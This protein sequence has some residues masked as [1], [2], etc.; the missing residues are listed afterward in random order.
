PLLGAESVLDQV[1]QLCDGHDQLAIGFELNTTL[2]LSSFK[3]RVIR[4]L[5][6]LRYNSP[7]VGSTIESGR[8]DH[9]LRSWVYKPCASLQEARSWAERTLQEVQLKDEDLNK[10]AQILVEK[11][12]EERVGSELAGQPFI[13]FLVTGSDGH[14]E[15]VPQGIIFYA[16][17]A[18]LDGAGALTTFKLLFKDV[19]WLGDDAILEELERG[20]EVKNLPVGPVKASGGPKGDWDPSGVQMIAQ[21]MTVLSQDQP[22]H[23][24]KP[25]RQEITDISKH[26]RV[27]RRLNAEQTGQLL[28]AAKSSGLSITQVLDA[29]FAVGTFRH[30][31][32]ISGNVWD[33]HI[34][35]Y[36]AIINLRPH[37]QPMYPGHDPDTFLCIYDAGIPID[38]RFTP[39]ILTTP[40]LGPLITSIATSIK[41]QYAH[42]ISNPHLVHLMPATTALA[43]M[44]ETWT[45]A[46]PFWGEITNLGVIDNKVPRRYDDQEGARLLEVG[47]LVLALRQRS[48]RPM[49]H[50]WTIGGELKFQV[51]GTDVWDED[52]LGRFLDEVLN[53]ALSIVPKP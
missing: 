3:S 18:L 49:V 24:L 32:D 40:F 19:A 27:E 13:C 43:P 45:D 35:L 14:E 2:P 30:N 34:T 16:N 46:N 41:Q 20:N 9:Q 10:F 17:H 39:K 50:A 8:H 26:M 6:R 4:A 28:K 25:A 12:L 38:I 22:S 5:I 15:N 53:C 11:K 52:Y 33:T 42:F 31:P 29:S 51:Q 44:R 47:D 21:V 7:L 23:S 36:P 1:H 37:I 48:K